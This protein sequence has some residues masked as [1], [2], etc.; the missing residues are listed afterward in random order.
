MLSTL[1][2]WDQEL[3]L[4]LNGAGTLTFDSFWV[5]ISSTK[6]AIPVF[7]WVI[8][9]LLKKYRVAFWQGLILI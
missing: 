4:L 1:L 5:F 9:L 7:L 2:K 8:F 3:F 6:S